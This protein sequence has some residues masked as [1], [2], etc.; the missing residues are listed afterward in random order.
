MLI[1]QGRP[2][3][4]VAKQIGDSVETTSRTYAHL[5]DA[6]RHAE[7]SRAAMEAAFGGMANT[8]QT[9]ES[10]SLEAAT[11]GPGGRYRLCAGKTLERGNR[12][13]R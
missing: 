9:S 6:A 7:E 10:E 8:W 13:K 2:L 12:Q 11:M 5:F 4:Y 1:A 3:T